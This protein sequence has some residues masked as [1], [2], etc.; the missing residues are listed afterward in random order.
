MLKADFINVGDGDAILLRLTE[1]GQVYTVLVDCGRPYVEFTE[2]S[3]R[4]SCLTYLMDEGVERIDLMVLTHLHL[5]HI[6]GALP[7]LH[8]LPVREM[9]ALRLPPENARWIRLARREV[10]TIVGMCDLLN[11][12]KTTVSFAKAQGVLC[13]EIQ[14]ESVAFG[15]LTLR[16]LLPETELARRQKALFQAL[17][18]GETPPEDEMLRVSKERNCSSLLLR[19]EYAGRSLLLTGDA[20]ASCL[21]PLELPP[22]DV[23]KVPHHGDGKSMTEKLI[24]AL[25]PSFAVISCQNNP[26]EK[27]DR[28]CAEVLALLRRYVPDILC[29]ENKELPSYPGTTKAAVRFVIQEDGRLTL[30]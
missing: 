1:K 17:Y 6:G 5:D 24:S 27:K 12:W 11:L 16:F 20:Y 29:T 28:P 23:L 9:A 22:C 10:K 3:Q 14:E 13:R 25:R 8:N 18:G 4:R 19:V 21:E 7:I 26:T 15:G 30:L 2:K